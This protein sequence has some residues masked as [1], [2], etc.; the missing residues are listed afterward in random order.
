VLAE[1]DVEGE[2]YKVESPLPILVTC[3]QG[4]NEPRYPSLPN[5]MKAKRKSLEYVGVSDLLENIAD[6]TKKTNVVARYQPKNR[7]DC[8]RIEGEPGQASKDLVK[9]LFEEAKIF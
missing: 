6:L 9:L 1:R 2:T 8:T 4:L 7:K 3:Q 5:I